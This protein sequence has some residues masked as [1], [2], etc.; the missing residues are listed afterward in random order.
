MKTAT[1]SLPQNRA[2]QETPQGSFILHTG[3]TVAEVNE[4][5]DQRSKL[6]DLNLGM[7]QQQFGTELINQVKDSLAFQIEESGLECPELED[8]QIFKNLR[9]RLRLFFF[10]QEE[11]RRR[12]G[13]SR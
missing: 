4:N 1:Q 7:F 2:K 13:P 3:T 12:K 9:N 8:N 11:Y 10:T 6:N 5:F